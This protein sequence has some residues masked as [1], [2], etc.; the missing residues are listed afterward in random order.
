MTKPTV[1]KWWNGE[2]AVKKKQPIKDQ[3]NGVEIKFDTPD[4]ETA[5]TEIAARI[6][7]MSESEQKKIWE[8]LQKAEENPEN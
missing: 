4:Q 8:M 7:Q 3:K 6:L 2:E 1:Y 5:A